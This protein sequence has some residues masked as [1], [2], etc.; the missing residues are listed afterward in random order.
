[1]VV[2]AGLGSW[3][4]VLHVALHL[5]GPARCPSPAETYRVALGGLPSLD[6]VP[7]RWLHLTMQGPGFIDEVSASDVEAIVREV[8]AR[9]ALVPAFDIQLDRPVFTPEA[10]RWDPEGPVDRVRREI[11][12]AIGEVWPVVPEGADRFTPHVTIAYANRAGPAAAILDAISSVPSE[13]A[14]AAITAVDLIVLNR[15]QH[16]YQWQPHATAQLA[17]P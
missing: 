16:T 9:L 3:A 4:F 5:S 15:D 11:R 1:L 12:A 2:E 17:H 8:R 6:L 7:D 10:I 13:P 14:T